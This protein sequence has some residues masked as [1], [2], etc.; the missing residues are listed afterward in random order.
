[1]RAVIRVNSAGAVPNAVP[2]TSLGH[3]CKMFGIKNS[4]NKLY[5]DAIAEYKVERPEY[6]DAED[7][8]SVFDAIFGSKKGGDGT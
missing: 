2:T 5:E 4:Y 6:V 1:M 8:E 7:D 3:F